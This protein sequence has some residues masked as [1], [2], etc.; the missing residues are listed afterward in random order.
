MDGL[1]KYQG[2]DKKS[3]AYK[4]LSSMGWQEGEGLVRMTLMRM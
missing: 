1:T 3:T 4:L 2:V